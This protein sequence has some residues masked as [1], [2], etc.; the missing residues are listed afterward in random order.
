MFTERPLKLSFFAKREFV[1]W[2]D[3][4]STM[5]K[6]HTNML[7]RWLKKNKIKHLPCGVYPVDLE[8]FLKEKVNITNKT[9]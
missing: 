7:R 4:E 1:A 9:I 8:R 6:F 5:G 3:C 2:I